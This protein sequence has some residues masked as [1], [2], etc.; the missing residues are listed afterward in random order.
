MIDKEKMRIRSDKQNVLIHKGKRNKNKTLDEHQM[1]IKPIIRKKEGK[2]INSE[3]RMTGKKKKYKVPYF[4][5]KCIKGHNWWVYKGSILPNHRAPNGT[6]C[7]HPECKGQSLKEHM[8]EIIPIVK[9]KEGKIISME[10][11]YSGKNRSKNPYFHIECKN[12]HNWW[13]VKHSLIRNKKHSDGSWC[14]NCQKKTLEEHQN[15]IESII[16]KKGGKLMGKKWKYLGKER[17]KQPYFNI[18]CEK[19]HIWWAGKSGIISTP[20]HPEGSW[21]KICQDRISAIGDLSHIILEY[22]SLQALNLRSCIAYHEKI[23]KNGTRPDIIIK[24]CNIFKKKIER[25]QDVIKFSENIKEILIDFT[26]AIIP[27]FI[28]DKCYRNYHNEE[29][30]LIIVLLREDGILTAKYI[31]DLI[32]NKVKIDKDEKKLIKVINLNR[33]LE[34]LNLDNNLNLINF[35]KFNLLS[36]SEIKISSLFKKSINLIV[37]S[38]ESDLK[39]NK[40]IS[41]SK[42]Y[43]SFLENN[44][45]IFKKEKKIIKS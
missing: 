29:R 17:K 10:W 14:L 12:G 33:Y 30:F 8:K 9:K 1:D 28:L 39:L 25:N 22:L 35:E 45:K 40:L 44:I 3:W 34:F 23:L 21:C 37:E 16:R 2:I 26:I 24:R 15:D 11:R 31:Q 6:W 4:N 36:K 7:P 38:I 20:S 41:L 42:K 43:T 18:I 13:V 32:N 19:G 27:S 5:I